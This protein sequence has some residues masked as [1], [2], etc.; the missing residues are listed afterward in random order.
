MSTLP[1]RRFLV[2]P[3]W[4]PQTSGIPTAVY[5]LGFE[6]NSVTE[7]Q[8]QDNRGKLQVSLGGLAHFEYWLTDSLSAE[9]SATTPWCIHKLRF[10]HAPTPHEKDADQGRWFI[11]QY[12]ERFDNDDGPLIIARLQGQAPTTYPDFFIQ[13][14][15]GD[16][17]YFG[18]NL[19]RCGRPRPQGGNV[20]PAH[21]RGEG[22]HDRLH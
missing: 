5:Y 15:T 20:T 21:A 6:G 22:S 7:L 16:P 1:N 3:H 4:Q 8:V 2:D 10:L 19:V 11:D 13:D 9:L 17:R 12:E 18:A 14:I